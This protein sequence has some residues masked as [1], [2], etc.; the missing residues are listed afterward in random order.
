MQNIILT[1]ILLTAII[2]SRAALGYGA[3]TGFNGMHGNMHHAMHGEYY[4]DY[5]YHEDCDLGPEECEEHY[6]EECL[7]EHQDCLEQGYHH[8][9]GC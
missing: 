6:D 5:E 4:D 2:G 3:M 8:E 9:R 1:G 7:E